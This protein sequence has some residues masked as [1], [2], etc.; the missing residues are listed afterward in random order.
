MAK[1]LTVIITV[2][3]DKENLI[4]TILS[5]KQTNLG[6]EQPKIL[7]I[8]DFS[9]DGL[10]ANDVLKFND[11]Y[12][13]RNERR[14]GSGISKN[15]GIKNCKTD[16]F[17]F[18]DS[19]V[20]FKTFGWAQKV[21]SLVRINKN[22]FINLTSIISCNDKK[23]DFIV[24]PKNYGATIHLT[25]I[26]KNGFIKFLEKEG[27]PIKDNSIYEIPCLMGSGYASSVNWFNSIKG[28]DGVYGYG[29]DEQWLSLK[30]WL[31]GGRV[32]QTTE[33][34][35]EYVLKNNLYYKDEEWT[36]LYNKIALTKILLPENFYNF[37]VKN[38]AISNVNKRVLSEI[39]NNSSINLKRQFFHDKIK[40]NFKDYCGKFNIN[41]YE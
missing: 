3:N 1:N 40:L 12:Y 34:E 32:L 24:T 31:L 7:V 33:I 22:C 20:K 21:E 41:W 9:N 36:E 38:M 17:L 6:C 28:F 18:I 13:I 30:T 39:N 16:Y 15:I 19:N 23:F 37:I 5:I 10:C 26:E 4:E 29:A 25:K 11:T 27:L 8:D 14:L 2:L 35:I